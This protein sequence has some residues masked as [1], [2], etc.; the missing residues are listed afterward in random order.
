MSQPKDGRP[1]QEHY[2]CQRYV[3]VKFNDETPL[4]KGEFTY[5]ELVRLLRGTA[6]VGGDYLFETHFSEHLQHGLSELAQRAVKLHPGYRPPNLRSYRQI[7]V[8]DETEGERLA[9]QLREWSLVN[10]AYLHPGAVEPPMPGGNVNPQAPAQVHLQPAPIGIDAI[11][12]WT[13]A[14][15]RGEAQGL[16]DVEWGW[17]QDHPD[18]AC[19]AFTDIE[20]DCYQKREHGT[21]VLG[22]IAACDNQI[23][24][25]G[26]TPSLASIV[27]VGQWRSP[28]ECVT[29]PAVAQACLA[30]SPG[31]ILLLEA[32][33]NMFGFTGIPLEAEPAV[34]DIVELATHGDIVVVAAAGNGGKLLDEIGDNT[35]KRI[36]DCSLQD[37]GAIIVGAA[38]PAPI[39]GW[40]RG[41]T[42][43]YGARVD[44]FAQG[45]DVVT[46]DTDFWDVGTYTDQFGGTSAA[47]AI[48][49]GA[50][51]AVQGVASQSL[52]S[53]LAPGDLR[54]LLAD[55]ALNT[56]AGN[57][58]NNRIGVM[59][60]LRRIIEA[61]LSSSP[62]QP[63][64]SGQP[65]D[66]LLYS[67]EEP[68]IQ[69]KPDDEERSMSEKT[70][71]VFLD[72]ALNPP[73]QVDPCVLGRRKMKWRME[74]GSANFRFVNIDFDPSDP[75]T[76]DKL[77]DDK[78]DVTN[79]LA[80][81]HF[82]YTLT[83]EADDGTLYTTTESTPPAPGDKPVIRN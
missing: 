35:G 7:H 27:T 40:N 44:C 29:A 38:H 67:G 31:D 6:P 83:V 24:C 25:V 18:L 14:G 53:R 10:Y 11:Y 28:T 55:P 22:V 8:A 75:F 23:H 19:Q 17:Q 39:S 43:C 48:V 58:P 61:L 57:S 78:L 34:F 4:P 62:P 72:T 56:A 37:S 81:G 64:A 47:A 49:A 54:A 51:L 42:S 45:S 5:R 20:P 80:P 2:D 63:A 59:P 52:D 66:P 21:R 16:A 82:K 68:T 46:L 79:S 33:T 73:V 71:Y 69:P 13:I 70:V 9:A 50:A 26:I 65:A 60:D 36:F 76:V 3:V 12:A 32:Q 30:L 15:G 1:G 41:Y 77:K 74:P